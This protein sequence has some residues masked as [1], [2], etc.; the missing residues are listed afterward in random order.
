MLTAGKVC[1]LHFTPGLQSA[2]KLTDKTAFFVFYKGESKPF[3]EL[4]LHLGDPQGFGQPP[5]TS[6]RQV[7]NVCTVSA[8][9]AWWI[10]S[11][12]RPLLRKAGKPRV[13]AQKP[14]GAWV[15]DLN[16]QVK[17]S[18]TVSQ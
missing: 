10:L 1:I 2:T 13:G 11:N 16:S 4:V 7:G 5:I 8:C 12:L 18:S 17:T 15:R 14:R 6:M 9:I 3:D